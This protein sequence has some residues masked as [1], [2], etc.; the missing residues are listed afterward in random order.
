[1]HVWGEGPL[2]QRGQSALRAW[3]NLCM[4]VEM[5]VLCSQRNGTGGLGLRL[6]GI[7]RVVC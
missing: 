1:M 5:A 2:L 3:P 6:G 4:Y 7:A